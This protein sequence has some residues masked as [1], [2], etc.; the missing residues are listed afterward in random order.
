[1]CV[2]A[3]TAEAVNPNVS[4]AGVVAFTGGPTEPGNSALL[5]LAKVGCY[6]SAGSV[7]V[8]PAQGTYGT[9]SHYELYG[10]GLHEWDASITKDWKFRERFG[11]QFRFEAYNVLN[12]TQYALPSAGL[13]TPNTF[14]QAQ[15]TGNNG[16]G[17]NGTGGP[18]SFQ[19]GLKLSF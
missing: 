16:N 11:A 4:S 1:M 5:S 8:P 10:K 14:G 9:M 7:I 6:V 3:A 18:R 12:R 17:F 15:A 2:T 19:L 13:A